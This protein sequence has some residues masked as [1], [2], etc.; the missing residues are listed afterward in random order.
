[1]TN[2]HQPPDT[3]RVNCRPE[4]IRLPRPGTLCPHTGL[5]RAW[6]YAAAA[7]GHIKTVSLR[8]RGKKRGVRLVFYDSV[9]DYVRRCAATQNGSA[10]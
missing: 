2:L 1:M 9:M 5:T 7:Q 10:S 6:L 8:Q 4:L 3:D